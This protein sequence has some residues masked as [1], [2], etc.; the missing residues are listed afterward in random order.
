ML[1][2]TGSGYSW[3]THASLNRIT[4]WS[5]DLVRDDWGKYLY[6]RDVDSGA[7]WSAGWHPAGRDLEAYQVRHGFGYS[8]IEWQRETLRG[9]LTTFVPL[10]DPCEVW[11]LRLENQ[12]DRPRRLQLFTYLEW[13][14]GASPDWH[15]EFHHLFIETR[16]DE[17]HHAMLATKVLW[18]LPGEKGPHLNRNWPYVAFH[19]ASISP[20][21]YDGDKAAFLGRNGRLAMPCALRNGRSFNTSGRGMDAIASLQVPLEIAPGEAVEVVFTLGVVT[22]ETQALALA[23]KYKNPAAAHQELVNVNN[24][25]HELTGRLVIETPE[26]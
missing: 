1:S 9:S 12:G 8:I 18:E 6:I 7:F 22:D 26:T 17:V 25:W 20:S 2:Q 19:S 4:R 15:R 24:L 13:L 5:Q 3:R 10:D 21:G 16:Y 14:L 11:L 23:D